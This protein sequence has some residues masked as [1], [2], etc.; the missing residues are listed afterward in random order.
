MDGADVI[1]KEKYLS[2]TGQIIQIYHRD[3]MG[4]ISVDERLPKPNERVLVHGDDGVFT[5]YRDDFE[6]PTWQCDPIGSYASD[7]IVFGITH[8]M[9]LPEI[10]DD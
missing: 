5:A 4:W 9:P 2:H 10:D 7:G 6:Y 1:L 3:N 8:W